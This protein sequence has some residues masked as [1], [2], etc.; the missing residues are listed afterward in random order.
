MLFRRDSSPRPITEPVPLDHET[1]PLAGNGRTPAVTPVDGWDTKSPIDPSSILPADL[2]EYTERIDRWIEAHATAGTLDEATPDLLDRL[3]HDHARSWHED[4]D[5][6]VAD[7]LQI[8]DRIDQQGVQHLTAHG[9]DIATL[10][11]EL[12]QALTDRQDARAR[13][14]G[15]Q[16]GITRHDSSNRLPALSEL[17][18][19]W[20]PRNDSL[21]DTDQEQTS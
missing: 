4:I 17:P 12:E 6:A 15:S 20:V 10:R 14:T 16:S 19:P 11:G 1:V 7:G 5:R 13:L 18:Q 8:H 2:T 9:L 3:I 21:D